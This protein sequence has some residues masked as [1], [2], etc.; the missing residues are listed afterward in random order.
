MKHSKENSTY[1]SLEL[2]LNEKGIK[3]LIKIQEELDRKVRE[4]MS[5]EKNKGNI[6][7]FSM[8]CSYTLSNTKMRETK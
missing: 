6:P 8:C 4:I 5:D 2:F 1:H 3:Q 7:C